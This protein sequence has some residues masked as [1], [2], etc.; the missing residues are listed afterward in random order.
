MKFVDYLKA[1][2]H[3]V[4][5]KTQGQLFLSWIKEHHGFRGNDLELQFCRDDRQAWSMINLRYEP[6]LYHLT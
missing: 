2:G 1:Q 3:K 5:L 4:K 6:Y